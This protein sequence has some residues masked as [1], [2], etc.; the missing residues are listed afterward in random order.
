MRAQNADC[1]GVRL[2]PL[3]TLF[4]RDGRPF[5]AAARATG[6]LP[7]P[8]PLAG[9]LRTA[10]LARAGFD[11]SRFARMQRHEGRP[12]A[13][14]LQVC[15]APGW[16]VQTRFRGPW[17]A[18]WRPGPDTV[19]PVLAVPATLARV[20]GSKR[21]EP[22]LWLRADPLMEAPP[23]WERRHGLLPVWHRGPTQ[24][25]YPGGFLTLRGIDTFLNGGKPTDED[26]FEPGDLYGADVRTGIAINADTLTAAESQIYGIHLL[27]LWPRVEK[28]GP[29]QEARVCLYAEVLPGPGA[30]GDMREWLTGPLALGGEGRYVGTTAGVPTVRWPGLAGSGGGAPSRT[31]W[32]LATPGLFGGTAGTECWR[33]DRIPAVQLRAAASREPLAVSGWDIAR[34]GPR[35]TRFAVPAGSVYFVEGP[36]TPPQQSL[37]TDS[38]DVA[39]GWGFVLR[40]TWNHA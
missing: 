37:C 26:W 19:E 6:G 12:L 3:D 11:F 5:D 34:N 10:L 7:Y 9:A 4:F 31:L 28:H 20:A 27:A 21:G 17:L 18:L 14:A 1:L 38:E 24:A 16:V 25:K 40:G 23:G 22:G 15:G 13:E 36:F 2:E 32:L 8:Q 30:P 35:P 39:Q 33:P 29:W